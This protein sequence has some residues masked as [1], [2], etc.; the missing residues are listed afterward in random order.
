MYVHT[1]GRFLCKRT[2]WLMILHGKTALVYAKYYELNFW[3]FT[4]ALS[5]FPAVSLSASTRQRSLF[6]FVMM[7]LQ[8]V[9]MMLTRGQARPENLTLNIVRVIKNKGHANSIPDCW[10]E[11]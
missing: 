1:D 4:R 5:I 9:N 3:F 2:P 10:Q 8:C 6:H 7:S 11:T